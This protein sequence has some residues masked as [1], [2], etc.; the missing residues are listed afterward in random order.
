MKKLMIIAAAL[1][2]V[3]F[4]CTKSDSVS[5]GETS[6][7]PGN[8]AGQ[9]GSMA[10]FSISGDY[11][12]IINEFQLK[13]YN[14][15]SPENPQL[16]ATLNVDFGIETVF[17]LD[18][19]LFIG[20]VN[21]MYIY[22][23]SNPVNI[24]YLSYY[25]HIT[26]CDPV[27]ANDSLAFVTLNSTSSCWWQG[28][29]N[30]LDVLD[31]SNKVNPQL[32]SSLNMSGPKGLGIYQNYVVVCN[33]ESGVEIF[34]YSNP[35]SLNYVSGISGID[36]YDVII[37]NDKMILVGKDG[38]FQYDISNIEQIELISNILFQ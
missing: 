28:G 7:V 17:T 31:I 29:A 27:V 9:G 37:Q 4:S 36:A 18:E 1:V 6:G 24:K 30:R 15:D 32:L 8:D 19:F 25:Q 22:D 16:L 20:S 35:Y 12:F 14:I 21:G 26:S 5:S 3:F 23:I 38:L 2:V 11:L 10:K 34:D 13:A 33:G